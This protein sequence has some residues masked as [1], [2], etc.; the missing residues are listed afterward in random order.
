M[1]PRLPGQLAVMALL[2]WGIWLL[3]T[4]AP[5]LPATELHLLLSAGAR[6]LL[7]IQG[8]LLA[9]LLPVLPASAD[10]WSTVFIAIW[11]TLV[12]L[13][14]HS[15]LWLMDATSLAFVGGLVVS[16]TAFSCVA[17]LGAAAI[18]AV[19]NLRARALL[20]TL[21]Q[22]VLSLAL[23]PAVLLANDYLPT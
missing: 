10:R 6:S 2:A 23:V 19:T 13:P 4:L 15:I 18:R 9:L 3:G 14:I 22:T 16:M 12:P 11:L 5:G 1:T 20:T 17:L 8:L 7:V 21:L